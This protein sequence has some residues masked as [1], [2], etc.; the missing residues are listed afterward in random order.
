MGREISRENAYYCS[1][2]VAKV[3]EEAD[4]KLWE[5]PAFLVKPEDFQHHKNFEIVYEGK[6]SEFK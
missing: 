2:F 5:T 4:V 1:H 6:M 3:I